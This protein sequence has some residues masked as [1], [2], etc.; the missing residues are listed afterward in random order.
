MPDEVLEAD[1]L[2]AQLTVA[3]RQLD[4]IR[5]VGDLLGLV[6]HLEDPLS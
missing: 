2:E 1:R 3:L 6:H 4:G 5:S